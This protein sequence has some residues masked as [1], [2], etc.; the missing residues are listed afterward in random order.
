MGCLVAALSLGFVVPVMRTCLIVTDEGLIDRRAV[1]SVRVGWRQIARLGVARPGG[2][3]GGFCVVADCRDG[4]HIDL[5]STR[6]YSRVPSRVTSMT[7]NAFAGPLRNV[8][9]HAVRTRLLIRRR[10]TGVERYPG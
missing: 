9:P 2:V 1:R 8:L 4:A 10:S 6:A 3:W 5:L 7:Y